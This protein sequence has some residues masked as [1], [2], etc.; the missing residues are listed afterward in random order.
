PHVSVLQLDAHA[1]TRDSYEGS[2]FNHAC[3]MARIGEI[4]PCAQVGI[5]SMDASECAGL[6]R[7]RVFFAHEIMAGVHI[8]D[9]LL[10]ALTRQVYIT[11][12]L[13]VFDPA[14]MPS[15]GTPEPGGIDWYT[16][17]RLLRPVIAE[18][19]IVGM[20]VTELLPNP[21]NRAPDFLAA[22]LIYRILS[23]IFG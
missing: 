12:D 14:I 23:M 7:E 2:R 8:A 5:R 13:D 21:C 3:V 19:E 17:F 9:R 10:E 16:L 18:K 20:D 6:Q 22:K 1:D 15:T 4:C 11:I